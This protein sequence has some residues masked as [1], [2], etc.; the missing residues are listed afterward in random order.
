MRQDFDHFLRPENLFYV[1]TVVE[2][3]LGSLESFKLLAILRR[4]DRFAAESFPED[5][6]TR[7][8]KSLLL[9]E[10][11][12]HQVHVRFVHLFDLLIRWLEVCQLEKSFD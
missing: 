10:V 2:L 9:F 12:L 11:L 1:K 7:Q 4:K 5:D 8:F 3:L 6:A